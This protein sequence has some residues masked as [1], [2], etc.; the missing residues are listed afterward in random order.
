[1][2]AHAV[3]RRRTAAFKAWVWLLLCAVLLQAAASS[4]VQ[5]LGRSHSHQIVQTGSAESWFEQVLSWREARLQALHAT[6]VF[7]HRAGAAA[8]HHHDDLARHHHRTGDATVQAVD[9]AGTEA[10]ADAG[11]AGAAS[12]APA[13]GPTAADWADGRAAPSRSAWPATAARNWTSALARLPERPPR[14]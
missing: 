8:G 11:Q 2:L 3:P 7:K 4:V 13:W 14:A 10:T 6:G 1:M 9:S 12:A 5:V